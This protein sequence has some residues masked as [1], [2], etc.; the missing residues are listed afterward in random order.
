MG[1][2]YMQKPGATRNDPRIGVSVLSTPRA[3]DRGGHIAGHVGKGGLRRGDQLRPGYPA[4]VQG[5]NNPVPGGPMI[6][7]GVPLGLADRR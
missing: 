4:D 1:E 3:D 5:H 6:G 7:P 2:S